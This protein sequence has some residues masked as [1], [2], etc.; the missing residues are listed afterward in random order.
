MLVYNNWKQ[1]NRPNIFYINRI[2]ILYKVEISKRL[3]VSILRTFIGVFLSPFA[4][5]FTTWKILSKSK[6]YR[7]SETANALADLGHSLRALLLS[8]VAY[9]PPIS[10]TIT[11]TNESLKLIQLISHYQLMLSVQRRENFNVEKFVWL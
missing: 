3:N 4:V 9:W 1:Y 8:K 11:L 10:L 6:Q 2:F 5:Q 7:L